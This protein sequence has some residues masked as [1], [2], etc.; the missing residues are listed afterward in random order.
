[1]SE[2]F[3]GRCIV[4]GAN[5]AILRR[6]NEKGQPGIWACTVHMMVAKASVRRADPVAFV[7]YVIERPVEEW[8]RAILRGRWRLR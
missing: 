8:Q 4:C 1:M 5:D 7:E 3:P 2:E 6:I